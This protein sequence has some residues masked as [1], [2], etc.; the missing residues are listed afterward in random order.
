MKEPYNNSIAGRVPY[1]VENASSIVEESAAAIWE[2]CKV[3]PYLSRRLIR[4]AR[5]IRHKY[6]SATVTTL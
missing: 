2:A 1:G 6:W 4:I 5:P 3:N